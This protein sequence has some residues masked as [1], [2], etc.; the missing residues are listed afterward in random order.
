MVF[1][2]VKYH[3]K[4]KT[5]SFAYARYFMI[6]RIK[7]KTNKTKTKTE[8]RKKKPFVCKC[9]NQLRGLRHVI[10][11]VTLKPCKYLG[12]NT[13]FLSPIPNPVNWEKNIFLYKC[14]PPPIFRFAFFAFLDFQ[15]I[16]LLYFT[17]L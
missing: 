17:V 8:K 2:M 13:S 12:I 3:S 7:Y 5:V 9:Q 10:N 11:E 14:I 16:R 4:V 6:K 1:N 15:I